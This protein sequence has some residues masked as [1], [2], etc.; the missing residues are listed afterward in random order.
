[1][2]SVVDRNIIM[3]RV[4]ALW[5]QSHLFCVF[6]TVH[7]YLFPG[8][9]WVWLDTSALKDAVKCHCDYSGCL[10][11]TDIGSSCHTAG[12]TTL[13]PV[14]HSVVWETVQILWLTSCVF[15]GNTCWNGHCR[16]CWPQGAD[17][18]PTTKSRSGEPRRPMC[19]RTSSCSWKT[20][21]LQEIKVTQ[22]WLCQQRTYKWHVSEL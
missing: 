16:L 9:I 17:L 12:H 14:H 18:T 21:L 13:L 11:P 8:S 4:T 10:L 1:M 19:S 6:V 2:R 5:W 3:R 15:T 22:H 7:T 20:Q